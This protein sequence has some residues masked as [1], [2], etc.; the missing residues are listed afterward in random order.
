[1]RVQE[2]ISE[3]SISFRKSANKIG[4]TSFSHESNFFQIQHFNCNFTQLQLF[5]NY[6]IVKKNYFKLKYFVKS[7]QNNNIF[8]FSK[9]NVHVFITFISPHHQIKRQNNGTKNKQRDK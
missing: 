9:K 4:G 2:K 7:A 6:S 8:K 1:M 3:G 5:L